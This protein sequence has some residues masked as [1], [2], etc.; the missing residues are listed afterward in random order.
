MRQ[1]R[2]EYTRT[3]RGWVSGSEY[4]RRF[5]KKVEP[6]DALTHA[7]IGPSGMNNIALTFCIF[8]PLRIM[9][10]GSTMVSL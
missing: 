6:V 8:T 1:E 5:T 3:Q 10:G 2:G 9:T 4:D 7:Q